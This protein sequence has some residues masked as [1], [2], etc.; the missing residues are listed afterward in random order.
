MRIAYLLLTTIAA[1]LVT[2]SVSAGETKRLT[3]TIIAEVINSALQRNVV[4]PYSLT[5]LRDAKVLAIELVSQESRSDREWVAEIEL[6]VDYGL[7]PAGVIGFESVRRGQYRL[8][9]SEANGEFVL[10]RFSPMGVVEYL[11]AAK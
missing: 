10:H 5:A 7:A 2:A 11:P 3:E 4:E 1:S 6:E 9:L 8:V